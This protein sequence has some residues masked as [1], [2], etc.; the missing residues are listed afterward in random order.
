MQGAVFI[1]LAHG[2]ERAVFLLDLNAFWQWNG[3]F[4]LG[5]LHFDAARL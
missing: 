5:P 2:N 4:A 1:A 3:E